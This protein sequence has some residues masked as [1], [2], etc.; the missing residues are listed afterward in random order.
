MFVEFIDPNTITTTDIFIDRSSFY[1]G[2]DAFPVFGITGS[3]FMVWVDGC[4]ESVR[5]ADTYFS[6]VS[7]ANTLILFSLFIIALGFRQR[8]K[9][10]QAS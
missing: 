7:E 5:I 10:N 3:A 9:A 6:K 8:A 2:Y 1:D 4:Y